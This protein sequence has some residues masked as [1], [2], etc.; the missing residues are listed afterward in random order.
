ADDVIIENNFTVTM[1]GNA[2]AAKSLTINTGGVA[3]WTSAF[4]TNIET[5]GINIAATGDIT[6][7]GAGTL[8]NKGNLTLNKNLSN[9]AFTLQMLS[10][11]GQTISG[12]GSLA[13]LDISAN[14]TNTGTLT[15]TTTLA[16]TIAS[17]L[18]QGSSASL[19]YGGTTVVPTLDA[20]ANG[21][22]VDYN[23]AG[24]QTI[25][26]GTYH[27][28]TISNAGTSTLGG[29][30]TVNN[31]LSI[32]GGTLATSTFQITGNASGTF[33]LAAGI[34]LT[35]GAVASATDV[36]FPTNFTAGHISLDATSTVIYQGNNTQTI[37]SVPTYGNLTINTFS[38]SKAADG[39]ITVAA[40]LK[41][42]SPATLDMTSHTLNLTGD[43]L[44]TG[45]GTGALSFSTGNFNIGGAFANTGTFTAGTGTVNYNGSGA[46][47][48]RGTTYYNLTI[49][50][51][52]TATAGAAITCNNNLN[53]TVGTF[54]SAAFTITVSGATTISAGTLNTSNIAGVFNLQSLLLTGGS[55]AGAATGNVNVATTLSVPSGS[56][57]ISRC[58]LTVTGATTV[59]GTLDFNSALGVKTFG[60]ITI[61]GG[62]WTSTGN[63]AFTITGN[64]TDNGTFTPGTGAITFNGTGTQSIGAFTTSGNVSMTKTGGTATFTGNVTGAGLTINGTGGTLNLGTGLTHTFTG[65]VTLTAGTLDGGSSLLRIGG[66]VSVNGGTFTAGTGTVEWY[67]SGAQ[68]IPALNYNNLTSSSSGARILASSG[69]IGVAGTFTPGTNVYTVT[70]STVDFN[71][72]GSQTIPALDYNNLTSSSSGARTL[73]SSGT[74]GVAGTFTPGT[75]TYTVTGSTVNFNGAVDQAVTSITYNNLILSV[76]GTKTFAAA[77]TINGDLSIS[78]TAVA[79]L[80]TYTSSSNTLTLGGTGQPS[81]SWGG[82]GSP[83]TY[84]NTTYFAAATGILN[85]A[86]SGCI[87]GTWIGGISTDWNTASN[88]CDAAVPTASTNVVIPPGG[89]QPVV[90][91]AAVCNDITVNSGATLTITGSNTLTVSGN[92]TNSGAFTANSSTVI[93]N[94][95][96]AQTCAVVTYYNLTLSGSGI[97]TF[98]TTPTVNGILSMEET[99]TVVVTTGVVTYGTNATLQYNTPTARTVTA[100]EWITPFAA[101]GGVIIAN[102]GAITLNTAKVF[103]VSVPLTIN[104][105]AT[106]S[107]SASTFNLTFGGDFHNNGGTFTTGNSQILIASTA[108]TQS[109]DGFT[110]TGTVS[111]TK[112]GGTATFTGNVTGAGLTINGTG[113]TLNLGTGLT[114]TFTG[115]VTL[116]AGTLDGGSSLLRIGG[117]VSVTGGTFT[118]GTGTVEWYA[119]G[120]QT[121]PALNYNNLTSSSSGARTLASSGT[122][123]VAG[124]FTPGTN[125]YTITGSTVNFDGS[126]SQIIP[127]FNY[128]NLTS[129]SS[130]ARILASPGTIGVAGTFT[131]GTNTYTVTGSTVNFNGAVDQAVTSITYNNLILSVSGI[132]TFAAATT[133]NGDMSISGTAVANLGTDTSSSNTLT[134]GGNGQP[135][136]SWGGTGSPATY[137]NTTYFAAATGILNVFTSGCIAGT[138]I[139]GIST[140]WNTAS[141]WCDA[142]VPTASTNVVIPSG[143]NQPVIGAAAVCNDIT[144]YSGATLTI[145]GSNTLTVSGNWTNSGAFTAN[146]STVI[147]NAAGAQTCAVVTYNNLTLSGSDIKTFATTPTVNGILSMEETATVV[148]TTGVVTYGTNATLQYNKPGAYT[149]T[150][151]EWL[152]TFTATGGVIIAGAGVITM[153]AAKVFNSTAPLIINNSAS[154]SMTTFL[155]TLDGDLINNGGTASGTTGGVTITGGVIQSIA[156]FTTTGTVSM[157][158]TGGTATFTGNVNGG[159]LTINGSG[160]TLNLGT[161]LTHTFTGA[162]TLT[163]GT[164]DGGSSTL[165][166]NKTGATAWNGTGSL[167]TAGT[168]TVNFGAAGNQTLSATTTTFYNL[169]LSNS[170]TKTL[171][172]ATTVNGNLTIN[173]GVTL[174]TANFGLTFGGDFVNNGTLTAGSAAITIANTA[175]TQSIA[176]FTTT[177]LVSMTKTAGTATFQG[178]VSGAGLTIDGTGGTLNLGAGLTHTFTGAVALINGTLN[179]GSSTLNENMV[180]LTAWDGTGTNFT[181][182][183]S[184]VNFGAAGAQTL[185]ATATTFNNLI[186]S[187]SGTKTFAAATTINGDLSISGTAAANLGT[188]TSSSNT[189]TLGGNGQPSGSWGGTGSGATYINTTYF[190]AATGILNVAASGCTAGTWIGGISTDWNTASNWCDAAVPT[191]STNV[192]IPPGGNQ[193]VIGAAA[194]CNDITVNSGATLTITGSNTLTVSGNWTNSGTFT[195]NSSTV[196]FNGA[197]QTVGTGPYNNLTLAGS[198]TKTTTGVTVN[199]ILSMEGTA[200]ASAVPTYGAAA[201]LQYNTATARTAG[202]EWL[203]TFVATGGV[204]IANTGAITLNAAKVFNASVPLT[205][206]SGATLST[207]ASTF[208]LTFGGDFHNN[209]GT[210]TT[211]NSQI[212]IASTAVT[213]SIDGF[214]TTGT[215][216][217]TKTAGTAT[218]TGNV[219]GAGLTINGTGGTLNLGTGLT[220]TFSGTWAQTAGTLDGGSST[221]RLGSGYSVTVGTFTSGTGTVEWNGS[222]SQTIPALDYYNLTI[223][224]TSGITADSNFTVIGE[225]NLQSANPSA[226][227]GSLDMGSSSIL[228][229]GSSA[230]TTG[231]GDVT[232][233]VKRTTFVA[234]TSYTFG[235][236]FTT[237]TFSSGG[238]MPS[239]LS[240]KISLGTAPSWKTDAILRTYDI[241]RTGGSGNTVTLNLH[242]LD[243]ELNANPE[244]DLF[245]W[246]YQAGIPEIDAHE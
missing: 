244:A 149:A 152:A 239:E 84:I 102:S 33:T 138:W 92:W 100:E 175:T 228:T 200:T 17:T 40:N 182:G 98:A 143:G 34:T 173:N 148:V 79:N 212:L 177:G 9:V 16:S 28:L 183:T 140:D 160:G 26:T 151:E 197:D 170:G 139:G 159:A 61:S 133:I 172:S 36:T 123:G 136:G 53:V 129:S 93:Y 230:I 241:V 190:A 89:N 157:T 42:T 62:T 164:L 71:G 85:V 165:N 237:T 13:K 121:I 219:N 70:G 63:S 153:G 56:A 80:G 67:A 210:F 161:G 145:T 112:T 135:S 128:N 47:T 222:G 94:A 147:Y 31:N 166:E 18:T 58:N 206:N 82:T 109:I 181:A 78:G 27:N 68:T 155:L 59:S 119:S 245:F 1:D 220:H 221:L 95:A 187:A 12:T 192:V 227:K 226:I 130:G 224:N 184:T 103:N 167:F 43:Y 4:T 162:V 236:Q 223:N 178:N 105:G 120:A 75:N 180:S 242:Y 110:T 196:I 38:G 144:V 127:A 215:V 66:S 126:G 52:S 189:L 174:A 213:Q 60:D 74:I 30:I 114:H 21:N 39:D 76:S 246:D 217:M 204:I 20:T 131:P 202:L 6:G 214:T 22:T 116:T 50:S 171:G 86:T 55:I 124:T 205:I 195:A 14:T 191:A 233:I 107:T 207:S 24:N 29:A 91:A 199:G 15:V 118:A 216:S 35:I 19:T 11:S 57:T 3:T 168:S 150:L 193:P 10:G 46:Q 158:K 243:S 104:S 7:A 185:S 37:S 8:T 88:W 234:A 81:G 154:L 73:A 113:G 208:N 232:G 231:Q 146:S 32:T 209:G 179:G 188:Y 141:N 229:M 132:K 218:F 99:A 87:A 176:G 96:G 211:G 90:G 41:T 125:T 65:V 201:T 54:A 25:Q 51:G 156:A 203:N 101:T 111:M 198:G 134:L 77:T 5:G 83:A 163:A 69:T 169:T 23:G 97:K 72:S 45:T 238:T 235:N 48:V 194:V 186:L 49:T 2:G 44:G 122:I 106:L 64:F 137:I 142:A 115:A 225:L 108:V 117:S 240:F